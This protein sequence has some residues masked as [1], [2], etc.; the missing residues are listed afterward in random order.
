[1][2]RYLIV[3]KFSVT[4]NEMPTVGRR[5]NKLKRDEFPEIVWEHSHVLI[6]DDGLVTT[7]CVYAAPDEETVRQHAV[8]L[9]QHEYWIREIAGDVTPADFPL[10]EEAAA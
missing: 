1:M 8:S 5:S 7:Y 6:E 3:R 2:P 9:G 4:E 10:E